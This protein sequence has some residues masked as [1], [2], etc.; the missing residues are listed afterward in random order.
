MTEKPRTFNKHSLP[1][2]ESGH[3][4][5]WCGGDMN[6]QCCEGDDPCWSCIGW[7]HSY[8]INCH[9]GKAAVTNPTLDAEFLT[10]VEAA[11]PELE[12]RSH[13]WCRGK[14]E[15]EIVSM[16]GKTK[17]QIGILRAES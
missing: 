5:F 13:S 8:A 2:S 11:L 16:I 6:G 3:N 15:P 1:H 4:P 10:K 7:L 14:S 12:A 9:A 17:E